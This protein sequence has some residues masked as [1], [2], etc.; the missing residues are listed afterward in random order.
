MYLV[1]KPLLRVGRWVHG[2]QSDV[3]GAQVL[4]DAALCGDFLVGVAYS[5]LSERTANKTK[6]QT[7]VSMPLSAWRQAP[8]N[9][10][11]NIR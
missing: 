3:F 1:Y 2:S 5:K 7:K 10:A 8:N 6:P 4:V 9:K 11:I